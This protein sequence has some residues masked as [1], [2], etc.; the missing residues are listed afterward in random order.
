MSEDRQ[1]E[2]MLEKNQTAARARE[3][4]R[5]MQEADRKARD[6]QAWEADLQAREDRH[7]ARRQRAARFQD[8]AAV[9]F[10]ASGAATT[11]GSWA[12]WNQAGTF[13]VLGALAL[14]VVLAA[15][16]FWC[17]GRLGR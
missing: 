13:P 14:S 11:F 7:S 5:R 4:G 16:G 3:A 2:R 17:G 6:L 10:F 9:L 15:A 8:T 12:Y 1:L